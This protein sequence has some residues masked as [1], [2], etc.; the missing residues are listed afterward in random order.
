MKRYDPFY[1]MRFAYPSVYSPT[2]PSP[3]LLLLLSMMPT[4]TNSNAMHELLELHAVQNAP[5][6][7]SHLCQTTLTSFANFVQGQ[8]LVL[9]TVLSSQTECVV[10]FCNRPQDPFGFLATYITDNKPKHTSAAPKP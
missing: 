9:H 3:P 4:L 1:F 8:S 10:V 2:H 6:F 5:L 7:A